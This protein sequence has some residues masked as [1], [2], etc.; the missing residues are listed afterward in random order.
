MTAFEL[1]KGTSESTA[2]NELRGFLDT[3]NVLVPELLAATNGNRLK[4]HIPIRKELIYN[5]L[6]IMSVMG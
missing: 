6:K 3:E 1:I 2:N 4:K 5:M